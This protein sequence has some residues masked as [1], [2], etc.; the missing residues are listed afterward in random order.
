LDTGKEEAVARFFADREHFDHV[1]MSAAQ[2]PTGPVRGLSLDDAHRAMD[3][4]F[5][6]AYRL[7]RAAQIADGGSLT[8]VRLPQR[9]P[10]GRG[11]APGSHQRGARS[12]GARASARNGA[13]SCARPPASSSNGVSNRTGGCDRPRRHSHE[14]QFPSPCGSPCQ[15]RPRRRGVR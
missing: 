15:H 4:R 7:A 1:V 10:F 6:G 14:R 2:T 12:A 13:C 11:G 3:S 9:A 8:F 5:W